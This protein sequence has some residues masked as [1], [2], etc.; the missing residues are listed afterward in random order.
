MGGCGVILVIDH[1][2][3]FRR[4]AEG[5]LRHASHPV[6]A[7]ASAA[8][9]EEFLN[10]DPPALVVLEAE[11]PDA[12]GLAM[13]AALLERYGED[14]PVILT[15]RA[16]R[17]PFDQA[18][19]ILLGA[20]DYITKPADPAELAARVRRSLKRRA[21]P[22]AAPRPAPA[23]EP[24]LSPRQLEILGLLAEGRTQKQIAAALV[25]SPK[26]V[27]THI[28]AVLGRLGVHNRAQAVAEAFRRGIVV[29]DFEAHRLDD[30]EGQPAL[31]SA[32]VA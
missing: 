26:T 2:P 12:N 8:A 4:L 3:R 27:G 25:I 13:L 29:T 21:F 7:V 24:G 9:A 31:P 10:G 15:S 18:A 5:A 22:A 19:G 32:V 20:D 30:G 28:Q 23:D 11:L 17:E 6:A 14:L 16:R 1:D